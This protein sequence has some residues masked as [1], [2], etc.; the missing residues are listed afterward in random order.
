ME[1]SVWQLPFAVVSAYLKLQRSQYYP[2]DKLKKMQLDLLQK[3]LSHAYR[4]TKY[5]RVLLD[6]IG[7]THPEKIDWSDWSGIPLLEKDTLRKSQDDFLADNASRYG[8]TKDS[9]S[10]STGSPLHFVLSDAAQAHKIASLLRSF[11]WAGY[12]VHAPTLNVQSYYFDDADFK[13]S[14]LYNSLR[15]D[16]NRLHRESC[17]NL[18]QYLQKFKPQIIIGFPFDILTIGKFIR[19]AGFELPRPKSVIT[20][21]ETLSEMRRALIA[22]Y[23][24]APVFDFY[25][26]H[27]GC[28]LISQCEKGNLHIAEDFAYVEVL[29]SAGNSSVNEGN[30][31]GTSF[32]NYSMPFIRYRIRDTVILDDRPCACGRQHRV[33]KQ[34]LGKQSDYIQTPDGRLLGAVMSHAI[35]QADGVL[36]SQCVQELLDL[37]TINLVVDDHYNTES[38]RKLEAGLRKRLGKEM[39]LRFNVVSQLEKTASGKTPFIISR[40]GNTYL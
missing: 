29:D 16:S 12:R 38:E 18:A 39:R 20:Y 27:E 26:L 14:R 19:E 4:H 3:L 32:Y 30:L 23:F 17:L 1:K 25:S 9:T 34:I 2:A 13:Y 28:A 33:V 10:G 8:V 15:F 5:Y 21:G 40:L 24:E 37:I 11:R 35:D 7:L 31:V 6:E 36:F 22:E